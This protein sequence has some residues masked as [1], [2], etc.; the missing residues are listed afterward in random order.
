MIYL[1]KGY[2]IKE[3]ENKKQAL[4]F[5]KKDLEQHNLNYKLI[6]K[7]INEDMEILI[8]QYHTLYLETYILHQEINLRN[9]RSYL[10]E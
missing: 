10:Y 7:E 3:F 8:Y 6:Y 4:E 2:T 5:I 1:T 9:K